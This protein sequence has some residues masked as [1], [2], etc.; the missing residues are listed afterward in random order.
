[1]KSPILGAS[2]RARSVNAAADVCINL[3]PE[4]I[5]KGGK[6][7]GAL[8][9]CPGTRLLATVGSGPIRGEWKVGNYGYVV[10][11][12][13]F[14]QID[15]DW[16]ATFIGLVTG[17]GNVSMDDNGTQIFI[18]CDP[19]GFIY[20]T[21]TGVFS[22]VTDPDFPGA[23]SVGYVDGYFVFT[24]PDSQQFW[25]SAL[26]DGTSVDP[27]DFASAEGSPDRVI[28]LIVDHSEVWLFGD[29][30]V[31]VWYDAGT[32]DFPLARIQGAYI[33][34]GCAS[35]NSICKMDNSVFWL[36][37]DARGHG[38][39]WRANGYTPV[40]ISTHAIEYA[41]SLW[42]DL[43]DVICYTYQEEGHAFL[44]MSSTTA[45]ETFCYDA[46]TNL[47]H[48]RAYMV[49][50][51]G[52]LQRHRSNCH[53]FFNGV[54]VVG[55]YVSGNLYA[56]EM[57]THD[58]DEDA[59]KWVRAWR[60][61]PTGANNLN[62]T[63]Q[64]SLQIDCETGVGLDGDVQGSDPTVM[65][66]WSDDGG[67][68]W[69]NGHNRSMGRIGEFGRRVIYRRLGSTEKIRDRVYRLSGTDPVPITIV[70]AELHLSQG[71]S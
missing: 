1:M 52:E 71:W 46:A 61:L 43:S 18:A 47:W 39:V 17:S 28:G 27:T 69:S 55:D 45:Q 40:R 26:L 10:S 6:E 59:Q 68:T 23:S 29:N 24:E 4:A 9:R 36:G 3:Y 20:N 48:Q 14:Y 50:E 30:S 37:K 21:V 44:M 42:G 63:F 60:A 64:H 12:N 57:S 51:T 34:Q 15:T 31:E 19:D 53:M 66:E 5:P 49:P 62:R 11:G 13:E 56:L 33:E 54:H 16:S 35:V 7:A 8:Y 2:Y 58:D 32:L 25:V 41:L 70:G 22:Q 65:L 38:T 67:H